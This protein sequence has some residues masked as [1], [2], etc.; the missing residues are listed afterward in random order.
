[1]TEK[2]IGIEIT[3]LGKTM[4]RSVFRGTVMRVFPIAGGNVAIIIRHG[5]YLSVY[6]NLINVRV[7]QG[8][9]VDTKEEIG[10]VFNDP[11]S[12]SKSILYF[13]IFDEK[14]LDPELW[15][16]KRN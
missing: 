11:E 3:S 1:M 5:K 13:M 4:V 6:Q 8:D 12:G 14:Y 15:I 7:K 2:N 9:I 10:D 16:S